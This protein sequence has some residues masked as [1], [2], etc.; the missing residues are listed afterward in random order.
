M[1][2]EGLR[3]HGPMGEE[4]MRTTVVGRRESFFKCDPCGTQS[5]SGR[6]GH[7]GTSETKEIVAV[8]ETSQF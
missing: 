5:N 7:P 2:R 8:P 6:G 4:T 3:R 1:P